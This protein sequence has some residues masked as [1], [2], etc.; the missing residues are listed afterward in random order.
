MEQIIDFSKTGSSYVS[1][2]IEEIDI[3]NSQNI[4]QG[5]D[6]NLDPENGIW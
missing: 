4:F 1:P 2:V 3:A 5:S 6:Q